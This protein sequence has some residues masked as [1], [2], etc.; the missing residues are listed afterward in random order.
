MVHFLKTDVCESV[1]INKA[2][3]VLAPIFSYL[4]DAPN[5]FMSVFCRVKVVLTNAH[6]RFK[7][8][9]YSVRKWPE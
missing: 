6:N 1:A 2:T 3:L 5:V 9:V 8:F 7:I 4:V